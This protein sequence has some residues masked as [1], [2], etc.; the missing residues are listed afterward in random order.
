MGGHGG[1]G[2]HLADGTNL[3]LVGWCKG[4]AAEAAT[5]HRLTPVNRLERFPVTSLNM[6]QLMR[7]VHTTSLAADKEGAAMG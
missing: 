3:P 2:T 4:A 5:H 6:R 7:A 1:K